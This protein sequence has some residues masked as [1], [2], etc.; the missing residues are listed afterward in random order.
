MAAGKFP[1]HIK[2]RGNTVFRLPHNVNQSCIPTL[3][4][5]SGEGINVQATNIAH[6]V[7]IGYTDNT[8]SI[9]N[10]SPLDKKHKPEQL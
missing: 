10:K 9:S 6:Q 7:T 2:G 4:K 5:L 8:N 3:S 1:C